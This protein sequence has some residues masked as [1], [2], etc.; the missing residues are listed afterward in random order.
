MAAKISIKKVFGF[1]FWCLLAVA[2]VWLA[3]Q[4][5]QKRDRAICQGY[6]LKLQGEESQ[7]FIDRKELIQLVTDN[8]KLVLKGRPVSSFN[9]KKMEEKL[10][11]NR[12]IEKVEL[13]FDNLQILQVVV[14][15][16]IPV[17][18]IFTQNGKSFYLD[19]SAVALPLSDKVTAQLP[20]FTGFPAGEK[21]WT[22][23][24]SL[25][26]KSVVQLGILLLSDS[27][28]MAQV[29]QADITATGEFE[30][31]PTMGRH[32]IELGDASGLEQK[33]RKLRIF[34]QKVLAAKGL[35]A[36]ERIK[37]QYKNQVVGVK[38]PLPFT[39]QD[40]MQAI[41]NVEELIRQSH[42][43]IDTQQLKTDNL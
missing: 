29:A 5:T 24:D 26:A 16:R 43:Q 39:K 12:W 25:L 32:V 23:K 20:L 37:L 28:W 40:S 18:R 38:S 31:L 19:S 15:E 34:Y 10:E 17:A 35:D 11:K 14:S 22:A 21:R 33:F 7:M 41:R 8:G 3:V 6:E 42:Q 13:Y 36:Y 4:A 27:L 2:L 1:L 30:L 9:L